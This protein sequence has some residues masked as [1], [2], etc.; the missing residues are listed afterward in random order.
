M[1]FRPFT[2]TANELTIQQ[3]IALNVINLLLPYIEDDYYKHYPIDVLHHCFIKGGLM[4]TQSM[5]LTNLPMLTL[6]DA[7]DDKNNLKLWQELIPALCKFILQAKTGGI[8]RGKSYRPYNTGAPQQFRNTPM[9]LPTVL[10][11]GRSIML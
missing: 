6:E 5:V 7:N 10:E 3:N 2:N 1:G 11:N 9:Y 8:F 4:A